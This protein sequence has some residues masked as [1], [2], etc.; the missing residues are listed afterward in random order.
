M[1]SKRLQLCAFTLI[2]FLVA[3]QPAADI[4]IK[5]M[6]IIGQVEDIEAYLATN[7]GISAYG[8]EVLCAYEPLNAQ[9]G[10]DGG[11]FLWAMCLEYYLEDGNLTLGSGISLP[12]AL[13]IEQ[14]DD[15]RY[16]I[17]GHLLPRD[18]AFY[19]GDVRAYFPKS[20]WSQIMP[21]SLD[22]IDAYNARAE[23]L[24][25]EIEKIAGDYY[26]NFSYNG[27]K[28]AKL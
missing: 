15:D 20:A 11:I 24:E 5:N 19:G 2:L 22:E 13:Q 16:D 1:K 26:L 4:S 12:V 3:C 7:V 25:Q 10:E 28:P 9:Q 17:V 27:L 18:G 8:G 23:S 21:E 14:I 6:E